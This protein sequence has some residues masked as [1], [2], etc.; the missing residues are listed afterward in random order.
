MIA[1]AEDWQD[2]QLIDAGDKDKLEIWK[3]VV[4]VR[5]DPQAIWQK[6]NDYRWNRPDARY[7]RSD[8]GGGSWSFNKKLPEYWTV[9]YK[10]L[11]FKVSPTNFKHT[12]LF[13]EQAANWDWLRNLIEKSDQQIRVL[14]LFAYTGGATVACS[15]AGA[16]EV[17][18]VD[19]AKGMV[20]WAKENMVLNKLENSTIRF[21]VDDALK[22]V[23]REQK[24]GRK[25]HIII[26]DPPSYGRGPN[27]EVWK[28]ED[29]IEE[30]IKE[31]SLLLEE[32]PVAF[33]VNAYTTGFSI[34]ALDNIIKKY[35]LKAFPEGK[36]NTI[37]LGLP[38]LNSDMILPC[39]ISGRFEL[40]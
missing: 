15:K 6:G 4:L 38:I 28:L 34:L 33:L 32:E 27:N 23:K 2:Y 8:K 7:Y 3:D 35:L 5:P 40:K 25:Y 10:D 29:K 30:L 16:K 31:T 1:I 26:M 17:V 20:S 11:V 24:R 9:N 13:P 12:G 19:A 22:F 21:I 37:Q 18:H 36:V 39:G 14:N